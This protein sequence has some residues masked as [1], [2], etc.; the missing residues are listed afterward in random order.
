MSNIKITM[1]KAYA[2]LRGAL[3]RALNLGHSNFEFVSGFVLRIS[4]FYRGQQLGQDFMAIA[5][6]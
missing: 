5:E 2:N 1:A 6:D 3:S 4:D